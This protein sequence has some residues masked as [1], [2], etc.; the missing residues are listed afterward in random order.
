MAGVTQKLTVCFPLYIAH[1]WALFNCLAFSLSQVMY[2][3]EVIYWKGWWHCPYQSVSQLT[4]DSYAKVEV[5][6]AVIILGS[7]AMSTMRSDNSHVIHATI[8][9]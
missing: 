2:R 3:I 4:N 8:N 6:N 5:L 7:D 9:P 1:R